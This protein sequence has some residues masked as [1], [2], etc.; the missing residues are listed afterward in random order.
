MQ[1]VP[2]VPPQEE[3][4]ADNGVLTKYEYT[5]SGNVMTSQTETT[6]VTKMLA[7]MD[8]AYKMKS[9]VP[10]TITQNDLPNYDIPSQMGA[11]DVPTADFER[12]E[13]NV[14][15][16]PYSIDEPG[17]VANHEQTNGV[18]DKKET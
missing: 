4:P 16:E 5:H 9:A 1:D 13:P 11:E 2:D 7:Y 12:A 18:A 8:E 6:D 17:A 14:R 10:E 15:D 3:P